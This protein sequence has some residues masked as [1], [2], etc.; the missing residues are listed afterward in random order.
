[1]VNI[2]TKV[3]TAMTGINDRELKVILQHIK[4]TTSRIETQVMLTNGRTTKLEKAIIPIQEKVLLHDKVIIGGIALILVAF[5]TA[6]IKLV[7]L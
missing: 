7:I 2:N 5:V 4:E 1:M 3:T 6:L